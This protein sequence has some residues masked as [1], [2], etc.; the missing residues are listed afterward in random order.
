LALAVPRNSAA[1]ESGGFDELP[2]HEPINEIA[3]LLPRPTLPRLAAETS[4]PS[5]AELSTRE[6]KRLY[7]RRHLA[8]TV[9]T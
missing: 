5:S 4:A 6:M 8:T 9:T 2:I 3:V 7:R 1:Q